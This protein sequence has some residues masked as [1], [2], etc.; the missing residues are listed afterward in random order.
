MRGVLS[1]TICAIGVADDGSPVRVPSPRPERA[2]DTLFASTLWRS[3]RSW[4]F[5]SVVPICRA[6]SRVDGNRC[7]GFADSARWMIEMNACGTSGRSGRS[8][9]TMQSRRRVYVS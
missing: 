4:T 8:G 7:S 6:I 2:S 3:L 5:L 9:G 1:A